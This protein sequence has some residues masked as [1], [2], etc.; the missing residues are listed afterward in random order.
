MQ[1]LPPGAR[2][3]RG[4]T[5]ERDELIQLNTE[6]VNGPRLPAGEGGNGLCAV[7][8]G[9]GLGFERGE[10][11]IQRPDVR[12]AEGVPRDGEGLETDDHVPT[13]LPARRRS[14]TAMVRR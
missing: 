2:P 8:H 10:R 6:V 14:Q 4:A 12:R 5:K 13:L 11:G 7:S 3:G 9:G 1:A